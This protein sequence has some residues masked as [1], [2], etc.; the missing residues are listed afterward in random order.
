M[1]PI[2]FPISQTTSSKENADV[3][4]RLVHFLAVETRET[5]LAVAGVCG[6]DCDATTKSHLLSILEEVAEHAPGDK[7][8]SLKDSTWLEVRPYEWETYEPSERTNIAR[9]GKLMLS[10]LKI[11]ESDPV[12]D[13]FRSRNLAPPSTGTALHS[14]NRDNNTTGPPSGVSQFKLSPKRPTISIPPVFLD[15][16]RDAGLT[17]SHTDWTLD[18]I[19]SLWHAAQT[20]W[21]EHPAARTTHRWGPMHSEQA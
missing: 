13:H 19:P 15:D 14:T 18:P 5:D 20:R 1:Y 9:Q 21:I 12:W 10:S 11:P 17:R 2:F 8:W 6:N 16:A 7:K 4:R 3:R